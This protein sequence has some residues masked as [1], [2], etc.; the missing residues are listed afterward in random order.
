MSVRSIVVP[1]IR[2]SRGAVLIM[3]AISSV[4]LLGFLGLAMDV[5]YM[6]HHRRI[7][8]TAADAAALAGG[9]EIERGQPPA[10]IRSSA[11]TASATHNFTD[12]TDGVQVT[13]HYPPVSGFYAANPKFVEVLIEQPLPIFVM[14]LFGYSTMRIP[15]RAVA[16]VGGD[17]KACVYVLDP[18]AEAAFQA[19]SSVRMTANCGISIDSSHRNAMDL[20]SSSRITAESVAI[21]GGYSTSSNATVSPTPSIGVPK[22]GDPLP[23]TILPAPTVPETCDHINFRLKNN[24]AAVLNPGVYCG[25]IWLESS[26]RATLNPGVYILVGGQDTA[27]DKGSLQLESNS[28]ISG[29][30]VMFYI[31]ERATPVPAWGG[32]QGKYRPIIFSSSPQ[33]QLSASTVENDP[34]KGILFFNDRN[35]GEYSPEGKK[36]E[37]PWTHE[38]ESSADSWMEGVLYF[39]RHV[40]VF[41]S[42]TNSTHSAF[43]AI[44]V[45]QVKLESSTNWTLGADFTGLPGGSPIKRLTLVE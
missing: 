17:A 35:I 4:A 3:V 43:S 42:S 9:A 45:R 7:M 20:N 21:N 40:V 36:G 44:V 27:F 5:G 38:F 28:Q 39:P 32:S 37:K 1:R 2:D 41:E 33:I 8:Q 30:G 12:D 31:T 29:N 11:L 14:K 10:V 16:G 13:V 23:E 15:A 18:T 6:Y 26:T 24:K 34:Y 19:N 22:S 25:G